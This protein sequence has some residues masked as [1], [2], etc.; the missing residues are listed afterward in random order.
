MINVFGEIRWQKVT[1]F[2]DY[3]QRHQI[4]WKICHQIWW[5]PILSPN[6]SQKWVTKLSPYLVTNLVITKF[7]DKFITKFGEHQIRHQKLWQFCHQFHHQL[8][9]WIW[10]APN[11]V[12]NL[13]PNLV[14]TKFGDKFSDKF[15]TLFGDHQICHQICHQTTLCSYMLISGRQFEETS[16]KIPW[17]ESEISYFSGCNILFMTKWHQLDIGAKLYTS[18]KVLLLKITWILG[19]IK[20]SQQALL[21]K[22]VFWTQ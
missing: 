16:G 3:Q 6:W 8:F 9:G 15:V 2:G 21:W 13:S 4:W 11:S 1:K 7:G 5:S 14:N 12:M 17:K 20:V 18:G 10:W 22:N 19:K